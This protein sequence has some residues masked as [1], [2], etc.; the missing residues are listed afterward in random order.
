[1]KTFASSLG[2]DVSD[3]VL[4]GESGRRGG[5]GADVGPEMTNSIGMEFRFIPAGSFR[6]GSP[7]WK[8]TPVQMVRQ[9]FC[10]FRV[11]CSASPLL[12]GVADG[13]KRD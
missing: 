1:M 13:K 8:N 6:M 11:V 12:N 3:V 7:E 10:G 2:F 5:S 4:D 9:L